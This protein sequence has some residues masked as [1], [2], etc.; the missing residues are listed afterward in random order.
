MQVRL[1][2]AS[3]GGAGALSKDSWLAWGSADPT[4]LL[5]ARPRVASQRR[6]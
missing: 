6:S 2:Y 5:E 4:A 3:F 1:D